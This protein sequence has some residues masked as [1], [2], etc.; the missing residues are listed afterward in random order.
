MYEEFTPEYLK[1][2]I[3][4]NTDTDISTIE[5]S[6]AHDL[7]SGVAY[8]MSLLYEELAILFDMIFY[9]SLFG[10][11][12]DEKCAEYGLSRTPG[13]KAQGVI[14][15][16]AS[17]NTSVPKGTLFS[18]DNFVFSAVEDTQVKGA[19]PTEVI[20]EAESIGAE[21]NL[22]NVS[23]IRPV[24]PLPGITSYVSV[25]FTGGADAETDDELRARLL[26]YIKAAGSGCINDYIKWAKEVPGVGSVSVIPTWD[27]A[28][29]V[30]VI[31]ADAE[32]TRTSD[33]LIAEV[34]A[35]IEQYRPIGA[36]V[37]VEAAQVADITVSAELTLDENTKLSDIQTAAE[38][39]IAAYLKEVAQDTSEI[40]MA[41]IC[42]A[43]LKIDGVLDC[44]NLKI[45]NKASNLDISNGTV[46]VLSEVTLIEESV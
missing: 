10:E 12:L 34:A 38:N 33:D 43:M 46:P 6:F 20:V 27:G 16:T 5:G 3:L 11:Y 44:K 1:R 7:A 9:K 18:C 36:K 28:G 41:R 32:F 30:K 19:S 4:D 24:L 35:H 45:N 39:A 14:T 21:Y 26:N 8:N 25:G 17:Y 2:Q 22:P 37:T 31:I 23:V 13:T 15:V 29:T 42:A 40:R